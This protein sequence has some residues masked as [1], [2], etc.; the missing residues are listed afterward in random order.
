VQS[1]LS[2]EYSPPRLRVLL[3]GK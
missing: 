1:A 2:L 3:L